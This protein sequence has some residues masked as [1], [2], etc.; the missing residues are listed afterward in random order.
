MKIKCQYCKVIPGL[1][2]ELASNFWPKKVGQCCGNPLIYV[3]CTTNMD[4]RCKIALKFKDLDLCKIVILA[5]LL[6]VFKNTK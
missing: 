1:L 3:P 5:S 2:V 4:L 6:L